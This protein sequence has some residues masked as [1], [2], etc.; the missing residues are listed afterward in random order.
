MRNA[1]QRPAALAL[2]VWCE[3]RAVEPWAAIVIGIIGG[4]V[5]YGGVALLDK[6]RIDD[7]VLAIPVHCFC[8][9]CA[10]DN[11]P[12]LTFTFRLLL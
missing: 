4:F 6:I 12:P 5:Y 3:C 2:I 10:P 1:T 8:G 9:I 7:V 11:T